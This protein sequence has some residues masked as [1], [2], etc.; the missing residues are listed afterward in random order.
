MANCKD[1]LWPFVSTPTNPPPKPWDFR[2][3]LLRILAI[4]LASFFLLFLFQIILITQQQWFSSWQL[5]PSQERAWSLP[6]PAKQPSF[7]CTLIPTTCLSD[8]ISRQSPNPA[9]CSC[10]TRLLCTPTHIL[11]RPNFEPLTNA[12]LN[13]WQTPFS[14]LFAKLQSLFLWKTSSSKK[15]S[16]SIHSRASHLIFIWI[17]RDVS[18]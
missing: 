11:T 2:H 5:V 10:H 1:L 8:P 14:L 12:L 17:S 15:P 16:F 6:A 9:G 4:P 3:G 13:L 7:S 18:F